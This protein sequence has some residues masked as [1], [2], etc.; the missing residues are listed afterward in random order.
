M[1]RLESIYGLI[2]RMDPF[3]DDRD[4]FST[5]ILSEAVPLSFDSEGRIGLP[6]PLIERANLSEQVMFVG[7]GATFELWEPL[8]FEAHAAE[9]RARAHQHRHLLSGRGGQP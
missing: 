9:A 5:A 2:D 7:K 1:E 3:S 8:A 6:E 4:A